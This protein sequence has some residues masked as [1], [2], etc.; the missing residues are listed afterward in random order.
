MRKI[1][2]LHLNMELEQLHVAAELLRKYEGKEAAEILPPALPQPTKFVSNK[3]YVRKVLAEQIDLRTDGADY[4]PVEQT[5]GRTRRYQEQVNARGVPSEQ[6]I[7]ENRSKNGREYRQETE[8]E[9]PV[10]DLRE[11]TEARN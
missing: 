10:V 4:V 3:D 5:P 6:V 2:E 8:G 11:R 1:W 7:E 9:H